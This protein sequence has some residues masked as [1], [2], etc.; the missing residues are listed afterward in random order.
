MK[1]LQVLYKARGTSTVLGTLADD[2]RVVL[3]EYAPEAIKAGLELSPLRL[4]L[5]SGAY[6]DE[7]YDYQSLLRVPGLIYDSLPDGWGM[8]LMDRRLKAQNID[9]AQLSVL[10]R[11]AYLGD[12]TMGALVYAP[13]SEPLA[14]STDLT[15]VALS[16]EIEALLLD[17]DREV[18]AELARAGGSPGGARPKA[19]VYYNPQSGAMSTREGRV[20]HAEP[21]LVK[22]PANEDAADSS[23]LEALY[24]RMAT[25]CGLGMEPTRF[26]ELPDGKTAFATKRFDRDQELRLHVHS[27]AG[28]LHVNFQVPSL[29]YGEFM[30]VTRRLTRGD[31]SQMRQALQRCIFNVIMNNRDDHAKNLAFRLNAD[32]AWELAPPFDLTF[33]TG[34]RGEHF[35]DVGGQGKQPGREHIL[36]VAAQGGIPDTEAGLILDQMRGS[37]TEG[38]FKNLAKNLPITKKT[39]AAVSK[40]IRQN[41]DH[42]G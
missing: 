18:L 25:E 24:A 5:R 2:G 26:F 13:P 37:L 38:V 20:D 9:P 40:A 33:C 27:L 41:I 28:M 1:E 23:A 30:R 11:L 12:N 22:F 16:N 4:P 19:L 35:M 39:I 32:N 10:D 36:N 6:P 8:R 7:Q 21:W 15:L 3:F 29:G 14:D 17:D 34:Y 31:A 42:L